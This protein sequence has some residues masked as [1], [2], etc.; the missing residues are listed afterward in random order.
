MS[1]PSDSTN[2]SGDLSLGPETSCDS[3]LC[4]E[5]EHVVNHACVAF[6]AGDD[7]SGQD[8]SCDSCT[9]WYSVALSNA[10]GQWITDPSNHPCDWDV[11]RVTGMSYLVEYE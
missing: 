7:A 6:L 1:C 11:G 3:T 8:T 5:D 2:A 4:G 10:L 9:L